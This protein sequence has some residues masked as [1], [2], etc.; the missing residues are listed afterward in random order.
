MQRPRLTWLAFGVAAL[1]ACS[2]SQAPTEVPQ[3]T[4]F[5]LP[6]GRQ[7]SNPQALPV[8][9]T[10]NIAVESPTYDFTIDLRFNTPVTDAQREVFVN[11]AHRWEE[12]IVS[13][14]PDIVGTIPAGLCLTGLP[15]FTGTIDDLLIDVVLQ[16]IDGPGAILG[17]A[18]P[19]FVRNADNL[20]VHGVMFFDTADL[21]FLEGLGLFDEV[22]VHE[23]GHV[24]GFGTLWNFRRALRT[25][26]GGPNPLFVGP[27]AQEFYNPAPDFHPLPVPVENTGGGGTRDGHWRESVFRNELMT[28]F[29]NLGENPLSLVTTA[30][31][32]D[33]GYGVF[34]YA[35]EQ[36]CPPW[37]ATQLMASLEAGGGDQG[38]NLDGAEVL[39][40]PIAVIQ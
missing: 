4:A 18:G 39:V 31:M 30:S 26:T 10:A 25:G 20:P 3:A 34:V 22:I 16:P 38:V 2:D 17:A 40:S 15:N 6:T 36:W 23:M 32:S 19:C 7:P 8:V 5:K 13:E 29:L 11:A 24:L 12:I 1:A 37:W 9:H 27:L 21:A 28:G 14:V 35:A 33:L